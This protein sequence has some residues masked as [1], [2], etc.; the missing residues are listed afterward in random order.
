MIEPVESAS[1]EQFFER[2]LLNL[3]RSTAS[4]NP[5]PN[6]QDRAMASG[7]D[8]QAL[9]RA[10]RGAEDEPRLAKYRRRKW[11]RSMEFAGWIDEA[12]LPSLTMEQAL[13]L[14][15]ALGGTHRQSFNNNPIEEIRDSMDFLLFDTVKLEGRFQECADEAGA[16]KLAGAGKDFVSYLLC[17]S[18]PRLFAVWNASAEKSLR[19]LDLDSGALRRGPM[20]IR[21]IDLLEGSELVLKR[22]GLADFRSV[23]EFFYW[24]SKPASPGG[25]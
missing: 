7:V 15:G 20:G 11:A 1:R 5:V 19:K 6:T 8:W 10:F 9:G 22:L 14:Y 25:D 13:S 16:F 23:D 4:P 2:I 17:L 18:E 12:A 21:Y 3:A 24:L